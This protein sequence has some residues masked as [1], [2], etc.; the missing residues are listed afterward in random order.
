[1]SYFNEYYECFWVEKQ[2]SIIKEFLSIKELEQNNLNKL[3]EELD[4]KNV[5]LEKSKALNQFYLY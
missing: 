4:Q 1:M 3:R 2:E 5:E